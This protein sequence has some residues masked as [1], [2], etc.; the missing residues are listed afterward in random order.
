MLEVLLLIQSSTTI[1]FFLS[2]LTSTVDCSLSRSPVSIDVLCSQSRYLEWQNHYIISSPLGI[3]LRLELILT[4]F[5]SINRGWFYFSTYTLLVTSNSPCH[6]MYTL[7]DGYPSLM[8][9]DP[10]ITLIFLVRSFIRRNDFRVSIENSGIVLRN[11]NTMFSSASLTNYRN[12]LMMHW[13]VYHAFS[14]SALSQ[15]LASGFVTTSSLGQLSVMAQSRI[16]MPK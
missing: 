16:S 2:W 9:V 7:F 11:W 15:M 8:M 6:M 5:R 3:F 1:L 13:M 10:L 14:F 12:F 4:V